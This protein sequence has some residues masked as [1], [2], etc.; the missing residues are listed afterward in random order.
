MPLTVQRYSMRK[1]GTSVWYCVS[2]AIS[3]SYQLNINLFVLRA[4]AK[5]Y[6]IMYKAIRDVYRKTPIFV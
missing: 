1:N 6:V 3:Y 5:M 4:V 2:E